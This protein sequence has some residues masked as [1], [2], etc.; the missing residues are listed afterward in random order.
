M[1]G[2]PVILKSKNNNNN[3]NSIIGMV[4]GI[5]PNNFS[6]EKLRGQA[7][8]VESDEILKLLLLLLLI[9]I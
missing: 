7:V 1:C 9:M 5:V 2:G 4:E 3:K 6:I 8:F